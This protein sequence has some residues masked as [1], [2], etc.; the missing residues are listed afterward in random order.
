MS[1]SAV[2]VRLLPSRSVMP[3]MSAHGEETG[4]PVVP[5]KCLVN[6]YWNEVMTT[7]SSAPASTLMRLP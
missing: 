1:M 4:E 5:P 6:R 2:S 7:S 3:V